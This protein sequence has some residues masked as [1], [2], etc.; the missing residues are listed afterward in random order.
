VLIDDQ[1]VVPVTLLAQLG[2]GVAVAVLLW[3]SLGGVFG[4]S[5]LLGGLACVLPN[6]FLAARLFGPSADAGAGK[7]R[8]ALWIGETGKFLMTALA[9]TAIFAFRLPVSAPAVFAGYIATQLTVM[10]A[11]LIGGGAA[12]TTVKN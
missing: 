3:A 10:G 4:L 8:R 2:V 5:A 7:V 1:R 6:A 9:F 12:G 11:L